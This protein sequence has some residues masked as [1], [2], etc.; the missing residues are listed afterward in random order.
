MA[1]MTINVEVSKEAHELG[2]GVKG[3]VLAV[4]KA[5]DDGWDTA[6]DL[7]TIVTVSLAHLAPAV[8]G[9]D[10]LDDEVKE[11]PAAFSKALALPVA[12]M[13]SEL[14]KKP[15]APADGGDAA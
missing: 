14:L 13:I 15:E 10:Q 9:L 3:V 2:E 5:L 6:S 11:D 8:G 12:D 1:K 4:K 7:P